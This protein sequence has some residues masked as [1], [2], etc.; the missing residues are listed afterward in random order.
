M[1]ADGFDLVDWQAVH[2]SLDD[3]PEMFRVWASNHMS[4]FCGV[5]RMQKICGFWD[6]SRCPR[7][8]QENET[9]THVIVC[10][11]NGAAQEWT[12]QIMNLGL[13]LIEMN[14]HPSVQKCIL[15]SLM[16]HSTATLFTTSADPFC[17]SATREQD[18]IGWQNFVEGKIT[19]SWG[20][21]QLLHY[22]ELHSKHTMDMWTAGLVTQLLEL[23]HGMW[24]HR[25]GVL[26]AVDA[27]GLPLKQAAELEAAIH[28]E[29]RKSMEGLA[30]KDH[31][32]IRRGR[33]NVM[34]MSVVDK[35]GWLRGI[36]LAH[37]SRMTAPQAHQQQQQLMHDFFQGE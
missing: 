6:N 5:G 4:R 35:R 24:L 33:D 37:E 20:M 28:D 2:R 23:T 3:F 18:E 11:G 1:T 32:F 10:T 8:K 7:C 26:H 34:S 21:L 13:W 30:H 31:H 17:F 14:T 12:N 9:M 19:R 16:S 15:E 22:Q 27:Q 25:N 29:F 36:Q